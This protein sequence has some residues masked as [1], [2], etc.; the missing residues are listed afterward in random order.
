[1]TSYLQ[2]EVEVSDFLCGPAGVIIPDL[3]P[4]LHSL[5]VGTLLKEVLVGAVIL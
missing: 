4:G 3:E 2:H 1:M 5:D